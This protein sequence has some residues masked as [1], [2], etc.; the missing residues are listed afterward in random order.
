MGANV[1]RTRLRVLAVDDDELALA[2]IQAVLAPLA[3]LVAVRSGEAALEALAEGDFAV[4]LLDLG[5]PGIDGFEVARRMKQSPTH[6]HTPIIFLTG[7]IGDAQVRKGYALGA[8]DYLLKPFDPDILRAKVQVFVD[9]ARLRVEARVLS[10]RSL[11]DQLTGLPNRTLFVDRLEHALARMSREHAKVAVLF[12][13]LDNFKTVNDTLGHDAG[14]RLLVE[15]A[16]RLQTTVRVTD[17]GARFG[18]DEFLVLL[19]GIHDAEEVD[20]LV[21]R[22]RAALAAPCAVDDSQASLSAAVGVAMTDDPEAEPE[23]LIRVADEAML[24]EKLAKRRG[25]VATG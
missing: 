1:E 11:H 25:R 24:R 7:Q 4:V 16:E 3:D 18:G 12:L 13:D 21:A 20:E 23:Q 19:E 22:I 9:L 17:T 8:A 5:L 15:V 2:M 6:R 14:D 10:H